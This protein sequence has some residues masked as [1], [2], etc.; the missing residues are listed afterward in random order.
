MGILTFRFWK[1]VGQSGEGPRW[2]RDGESGKAH[3]RWGPVL[4]SSIAIV[5]VQ[6]YTIDPPVAVNR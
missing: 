3:E 6:D 1:H 5:P 2:L 4:Y